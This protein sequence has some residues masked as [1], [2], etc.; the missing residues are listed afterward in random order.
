MV[1]ISGT[2]TFMICTI[3]YD[4]LGI[5]SCMVHKYMNELLP[6]M[7][8]IHNFHQ[9]KS[10]NYCVMCIVGILGYTTHHNIQLT[11]KECFDSSIHID[12]WDEYWSWIV[13]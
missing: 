5:S 12:F 11:V 6:G 4:S 2:K 8:I 9:N 3:C 1:P 10:I 13:I 7:Y